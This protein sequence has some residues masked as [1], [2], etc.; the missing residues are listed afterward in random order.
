MKKWILGFFR[1]APFVIMV[2]L[3]TNALYG[4]LEP[5]P[6]SEEI[7]S[8]HDDKLVVLI[9]QNYRYRNVGGYE[10]TLKSKSYLLIADS[11]LETVVLE[12]KQDSD[13]GIEV[14]ESGWKAL[15]FFMNILLIIIVAIYAWF[16]GHGKGTGKK[17]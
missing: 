10:H 11:I 6:I 4:L 16:G 14:N 3:L 15:L 2:M 8:E 7:L 12:V 5:W 9:G 17:T 1:Y 13:N